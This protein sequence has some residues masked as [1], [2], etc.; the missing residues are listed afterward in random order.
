MVERFLEYVNSFPN[1]YLAY[2]KAE[3]ILEFLGTNPEI[4]ED[5]MRSDRYIKT[6]FGLE[7]FSTTD[8]ELIV[9]WLYDRKDVISSCKGTNHDH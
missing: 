5:P 9:G 7:G 3:S 8:C 2:W 1:G 4:L 6:S